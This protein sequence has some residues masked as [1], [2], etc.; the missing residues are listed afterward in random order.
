MRFWPKIAR[1][2]AAALIAALIV[3]LA[4]GPVS[5]QAALEPDGLV[6]ASTMSRPP[7]AL[8]PKMTADPS[9]VVPNQVVV[10]IGE[11]YSAKSV[12]GGT[13]DGGRHQITGTGS[14]TITMGGTVLRS[15]YI[16]YPIDLDDGGSWVAVVI[17]EGNSTTFGASS[18]QFVARDT[19]GAFATA[20]ITLLL[21]KITLDDTES[22]IGSKVKIEG[23][24]FPATNAA[25]S[26]SFRVDIK[27][28]SNS[29]TT[30]TPDTSGEF[31]TTIV[32]PTSALIPSTNT[33]TATIVGATATATVNH[34]VPAG[35]TSTAPAAGPTGTTVTVTGTNF[36]SFWPITDITIGG[37]SIPLSSKTTDVN[38]SFTTT[39]VVPA[40]PFGLKIV[41]VTI[42]GLKSFSSFNV[43]EPDVPPTPIIAPTP[44]PAPSI[45]PALGLA[46]L[47]NDD[48]LVRVW[49]FDPAG[50]DIPPSFG[51]ALYDPRPIFKLA[52]TVMRLTSGNFYWMSVKENQTVTLNGKERVLFA[53]WNPVS[54]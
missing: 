27:Y 3:G 1:R 10:L 29:L 15:P 39:S 19:G 9:P 23:V 22:R 44:T 24:G 30:V 34:S 20:S 14:S 4:S 2:V 6:G 13:G 41:A 18:L 36:R 32:V 16:T 52:N 49:H 5:I 11:G 53:G 12:A 43:T 45:D 28:G 48:N 42:G 37:L 46:P 50:Q 25:S 17:I 8:T 47:I 26:D 21:R 40:L 31:E 54:W 38:G 33:I 7:G 35:T 51:W